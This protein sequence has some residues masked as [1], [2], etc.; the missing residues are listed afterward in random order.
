MALPAA[1]M[2]VNKASEC[3]KTTGSNWRSAAVADTG[4]VIEWPR[5]RCAQSL[6]SGIEQASTAVSAPLRHSR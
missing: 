4:I 1:L 5:Q 3:F 2:Q 6:L